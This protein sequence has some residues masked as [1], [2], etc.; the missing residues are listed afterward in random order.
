MPKPVAVT[1]GLCR[2]ELMFHEIPASPDI[3]FKHDSGKIG[4]ISV[5]DS[6]KGNSV[7]GESLSAKEITRELEWITP[8]KHQWDLRPAEPGIFKAI[9]PTKFDLTRVIK[10]PDI[11]VENTPFL[12]HF[13]EWSSSD[14]DRYRL[15]ETWVRIKGCPYKLRCDFLG[16]FAVGTLIGKTQE[17]DMPFTREHGVVRLRIQVTAI[18]HIPEGTDHTYDGEGYGITFHVE[19]VENNAN[20]VTMVNEDER[21]DGE[22]KQ[23]EREENRGEPPSKGPDQKAEPTAKSCTNSANSTFGKQVVSEVAAIKFGFFGS[24]CSLSAVKPKTSSSCLWGDRVEN[25]EDT[26]PS[27]LSKSAPPKL[28]F[29]SFPTVGDFERCSDFSPKSPA[30]VIGKGQSFDSRQDAE[31]SQQTELSPRQHVASTATEAAL[32]EVLAHSDISPMVLEVAGVMVGQKASPSTISGMA[33]PRQEAEGSVASPRSSRG[34]STSPERQQLGTGVF[35][36]GRYTQEEVVAFGGIPAA[37]KDIRSSDRIRAQPNAD[38]TQLERA[39][40]RAMNRDPSSCAGTKSC[41]K[42]TL[43]NLSN[44]EVIAKAFRLGFFLGSSPSQII[45]SVNLLK[46]NDLERTLITLKRNEEKARTE[47]SSGHSLVL[48][49]A[50]SLS[51]DLQEEEQ[52]GSEDHKDFLLRDLI[53]GKPNRKKKECLIVRQVYE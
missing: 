17:V 21:K 2:A 32:Q 43:S 24:T 11:P 9:F 13:E 42:F 15:E 3:R 27:P 12:L 14:L 28:R 51:G 18:K 31:G 5:L 47:D 30:A 22:D 1:Y 45:Q 35:L 46:D 7:V 23:Q 49:K 44:D 6:H 50:V 26:L 8:G 52:Q 53:I 39:Q 41:H 10:M 40:L 25:E 36:G 38:A 19:G 20:D 16:L 29:G 48:A 4:R 33:T 37:H 34:R